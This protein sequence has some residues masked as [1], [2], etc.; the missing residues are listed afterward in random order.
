MLCECYHAV[1]CVSHLGLIVWLDR[2]VV[3]DLPYRSA[4]LVIVNTNYPSHCKPIRTSLQVI[5]SPIHL[6][7][8]NL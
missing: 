7:A 5:T 8:W 1:V 3:V 6:L 2:V 4:E